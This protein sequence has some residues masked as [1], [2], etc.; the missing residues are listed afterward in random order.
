MIAP[1]DR[2]RFG[3]GPDQVC[4]R[5]FSSPAL[6][7]ITTQCGGGF[8]A[9]TDD[10]LDGGGA[11]AGNDGHC[12]QCANPSTGRGRSKPSSPERY[13]VQT[14][15]VP[16]LRAMVPAGIRAALWAVS[17]LVRPL[18][19][20]CRYPTRRPSGA[21]FGRPRFFDGMRYRATELRTNAARA[22]FIRR[23]HGHARRQS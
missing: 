9:K 3:T 22:V 14:S 1:P 4:C 18:L 17:V 8:Y 12:G 23:G 21:A 13:A 10:D 15:G 19:V 16:R 5:C 6:S 7:A 20:S 2:R 11:H